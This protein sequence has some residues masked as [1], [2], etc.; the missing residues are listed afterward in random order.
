MSSDYQVIKDIEQL[1]CCKIRDTIMWNRRE[2]AIKIIEMSHVAPSRQPG[3]YSVFS[4]LPLSECQYL[5]KKWL[6]I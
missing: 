6:F 4:T 5:K 3:M 2:W 1:A